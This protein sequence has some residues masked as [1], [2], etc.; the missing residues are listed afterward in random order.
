MEIAFTGTVSGCAH[1]K[2][3]ACMPIPAIYLLAISLKQWATEA[4]RSL[5]RLT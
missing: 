1:G 4:I 5:L 2:R 3:V